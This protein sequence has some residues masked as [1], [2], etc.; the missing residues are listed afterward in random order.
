MKTLAIETSGKT[1]S[2]AIN[3]N[4]R[5]TASLYY[6]CG[7]IHSELIISAIERLLKDSGNNLQNIDQFAVSVGPGSFT[8]IRIGMTA[9]KTFAQA[10]NKP[11]VAID[12]LSILEKSF[13]KKAKEVKLIPV[14]DAL[15]GEVYVKNGKKIVIKNTDLFI[16]ELKKYK[17][18]LLL[19]GNAVISYREKFRKGLGAY[20]V[21][22]P[23]TTH[24]PKANV[25]AEVAYHS[26]KSTDYSKIS[27]LYIRRSWAEENINR[28]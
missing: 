20:S 25:L 26:L 10:L 16:K 28:R 4:G 17:N 7:Q 21:S 6:D 11:V 8:G 1:F 5:D 13:I 9:V 23:Y 24:M 12:A 27:P 14:I 18:N 19:I 3:E 22:L 15:R 2:L